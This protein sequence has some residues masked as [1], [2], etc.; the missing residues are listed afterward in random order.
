[1]MYINATEISK[2]RKVKT[3]D[4]RYPSCSFSGLAMS[5]PVAKRTMLNRTERT[6]YATI[7]GLRITRTADIG[8]PPTVRNSSRGHAYRADIPVREED[9]PPKSNG[10]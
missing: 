6:P 8:W 2:Q 10:G 4:I 3:S 5:E 1:M 9:E 7:D